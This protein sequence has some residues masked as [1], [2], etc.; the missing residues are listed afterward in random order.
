MAQPALRNRQRQL[1]SAGT[2]WRAD[3]D[4][5]ALHGVKCLVEG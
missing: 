3:Q 2:W 1:E 5:V 4:G